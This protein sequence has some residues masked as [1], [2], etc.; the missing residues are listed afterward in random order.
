MTHTF[1]PIAL[2]VFISGKQGAG[3]SVL[4]RKIAKLLA[5]EGSFVQVCDGETDSKTYG[6]PEAAHRVLVV[7]ANEP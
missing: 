7:V 5:G 2:R 1:D 3:K 4:A 6:D